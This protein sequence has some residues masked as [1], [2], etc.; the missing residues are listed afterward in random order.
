MA[1]QWEME[2]RLMCVDGQGGCG[3]HARMAQ[4]LAV[5]RTLL[6]YCCHMHTTTHT[7]LVDSWQT[8]GGACASTKVKVEVSL[9]Q[10]QAASE[11]G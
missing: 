3:G 5:N 4:S 9:G 11:R 6:P 2:I 1:A 8:I 7:K 10:K